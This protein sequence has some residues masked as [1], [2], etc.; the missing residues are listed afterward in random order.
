LPGGER[1]GDEC[2]ENPGSNAHLDLI[3]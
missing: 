2:D 1:D 3:A